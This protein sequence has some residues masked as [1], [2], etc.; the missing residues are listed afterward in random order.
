MKKIFATSFTLLMICF[1]AAFAFAQ[2]EHPKSEHPKGHPGK[3]VTTGDLQKGIET[4]IK[5]QSKTDGMF[6]VDDRVLNKTWNLK[7]VK[8]HT[9]KLTALDKDN[10]F[11]CVDFK[12]D[13]GTPVDVDFYMKDDGGKLSVTDTTVH[14]V[15]GQARYMYEQ[16]DGFWHRVDVKK[17]A[18]NSN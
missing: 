12:A 16:K 13:D 6:H 7:L 18:Q 8:V 14:K 5:D 11:A 2:N 4:H 10:Y 17:D 1:L 3:K 15:N 9:D